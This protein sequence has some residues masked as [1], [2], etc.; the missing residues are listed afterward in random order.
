MDD[1]I[2]LKLGMQDKE[3][4]NIFETNPY[5]KTVFPSLKIQKPGVDY[6]GYTTM[7]LAIIAIFVMFTYD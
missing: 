6:Y 7:V 3:K 1:K 4:P 5:L 2:E